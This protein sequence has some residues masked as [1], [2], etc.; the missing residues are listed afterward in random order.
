MPKGKLYNE[1][2]DFIPADLEN[3]SVSKALEYA[4]NDWCIF[5]MAQKLGHQGLEQRFYERSKYYRNV[6][7][8]SY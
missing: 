1:T 2:M 8:P 5:Q 4:Y 7:L 6:Y 3:E